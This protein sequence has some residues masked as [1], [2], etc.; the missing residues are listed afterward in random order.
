MVN[1]RYKRFL[2]PFVLA[3]GHRFLERSER[4]TK[5]LKQ[6]FPEITAKMS[7]SRT[8]RR[9]PSPDRPVPGGEPPEKNEEPPEDEEHNFASGSEDGG[10]DEKGTYRIW[11]HACNAERT[12]DDHEPICP[13]CGGDFVEEVRLEAV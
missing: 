10:E 6:L 3:E 8:S 5:N 11:C 13:E 7:G 1:W 12:R 2:E 9:Q 4:P